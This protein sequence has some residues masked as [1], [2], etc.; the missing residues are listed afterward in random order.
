VALTLGTWGPLVLYCAT[1][2]LL[3][4]GT[5]SAPP[6]PFPH[7]DKLLHLAEY[8]LLGVLAARAFGPGTRGLLGR[9]ESVVAVVLFATCYGA[10]DEV[11]QSYVPGRQMDFAD[12]LADVTG[13]GI[14]ALAVSRLPRFL[15]RPSLPETAP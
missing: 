7:A 3:S 12:L 1:I 6:L 9:G 4:A 11:H 14:A 13:A 2:Y 15:P 5:P 8:A 10:L